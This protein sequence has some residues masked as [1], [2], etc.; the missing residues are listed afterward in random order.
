MPVNFSP[1]SDVGEREVVWSEA[2]NG[3][4][5]LV[6][7]VGVESGATREGLPDI[8]KREGAVGYRAWERAQRVEV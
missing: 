7:L 4:I 1:C 8:G 6:K 3:A 5:A 2:D